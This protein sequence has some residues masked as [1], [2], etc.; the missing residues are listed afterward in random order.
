MEI[1]DGIQTLY[2]CSLIGWRKW[3]DK[4]CQS[5]KSIWLIVDHKASKTPSVH[6]HELLK[7]HFAMVGW[8]LKHKA[9]TK[10]VAFLYLHSKTQKAN[11]ENTTRNL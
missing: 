1:K 6:W 4:N 9:E 11:R 10:K 2:A 3:L 5:E 8:T 7:M